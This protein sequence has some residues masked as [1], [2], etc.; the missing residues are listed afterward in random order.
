MRILN[1]MSLDFTYLASIGG[2]EGAIIE[3]NWNGVSYLTLKINKEIPNADTLVQDRILWFDKEYHNGFIIERVLEKLEN[4]TKMLEITASSLHALVRDYITIP[5]VGFDEH[6]V[7]DNREGIV[8]A[9]VNSNCINPADSSRV[10]YPLI[11]GTDNNYG[12]STVCSTRLKNLADEVSRVLAVEFL[13]WRVDIDLSA[14]KFV[15]KVLKGVNRT[16]GQAV[17]SRI[18]FGTKYGNM[19]RYEKTQDSLSAKN[20]AYV[21]GQG[22]GKDRVIQKVSRDSSI[23]ADGSFELGTGWNLNGTTIQIVNGGISGAK[24]LQL[25]GTTE[26]EIVCSSLVLPYDKTHKY[27]STYFSKLPAGMRS[28]LYWPLTPPYKASVDVNSGEWQ[29]NA[30]YTPPLP[31]ATSGNVSVRLDLDNQGQTAVGYYDEVKV[32]DLTLMYGLGNEPDENW[33]RNNL[34]RARKKEVFVDA[35]DKATVGELTEQGTQVLSGSKDVTNFTFETLDRQFV[36]GQDW[37]L[38]DFVTIVQDDGT[39]EDKQVIKVTEY[40][41]AGNHR[42]VPEFGGSEVTVGG[43]IMS[44]SARLANLEGSGSR[45][46]DLASYGNEN[47][48]QIAVSDC[49]LATKTGFYYT[50]GAANSPAGDGH[51]IVA[52]YSSAHK[53]Q[54]FWE[55]NGQ[56][57]GKLF[58]R[59]MFG[60]VWQP[61]QRIAVGVPSA[62]IPAPAAT[63]ADCQAKINLIIAAIKDKGITL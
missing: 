57:Y 62:A 38:G 16:I 6:S 11:L 23:L 54:Q 51:L 1:V 36:Y 35:R 58:Q 40:V 55:Y 31:T 19:S 4:N 45:A 39:Y 26:S 56:V 10:Q 44:V 20:V 7:S 47:L 29:Q 59:R 49:N 12:S 53:I 18:I 61:W 60:G 25:S 5:P 15:F 32:Y 9:F 30:L 46:D 8:R 2:Y 22:E 13:G 27:F 52:S 63:I 33:C 24:C 17:N 3:R 28:Q 42:I 50:T 34:M 41:E 14:K 21:G 48:S 37:D 43:V